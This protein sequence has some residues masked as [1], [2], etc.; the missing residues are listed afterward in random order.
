MIDI[1]RAFVRISA[2]ALV[3]ITAVARATTA[4]SVALIN[5]EFESPYAT[6]SGN[7]GQISGYI[8]NGWSDNSTWSNSSVQYSQEFNNPHSGASCQKMAVSSVGSGEA[9]F[10]QA[11]PVVAGS[12]YTASAWMRGNTGTQVVLRIMDANPPYESYLD[13]YVALTSDWQQVTIHGYIVVSTAASFMIALSAPG[14]VWIDDAS[15]S[16]TPGAAPPTPN[17]G[18][19]PTSFFGIHVGNYL[20]S[21]LSNPGFEPPYISA[22]N[23]NPIS[24]N[25]AVN[26]NDNSSWAD[27][28]VTYS[29]DTQN[30]HSG[31]AAQMVNVQAVRS[32]AVQLVQSVSVIPGATYVFSVWLRGQAGGS[33]NVVLQDQNSPYTYYASTTAQLTANWQQFTASGQINDTGAVLLMVQATSPV[34]FS[35]DDATFTDANGLPVSGGVP[36]PSARFGTLRLW[37]SGTSWTALEPLRG[38]WNFAPLDTSVAAAEANGIEDII[39]TLGQTPSWASSNPDDV[40][41][42]GAGAP[43]P[44][45]NIQDWRD[46]ITA[47]AQRYQGRI[48]HP[49]AVSDGLCLQSHGHFRRAATGRG[50]QAWTGGDP[51]RVAR[52]RRDRGDADVGDDVPVRVMARGGQSVPAVWGAAR[53]GAGHQP[54]VAAGPAE[55]L[56]G[57]RAL[58]T[59]QQTDRVGPDLPGGDGGADLVPRGFRGRRVGDRRRVDRAAWSSPRPARRSNWPCSPAGSRCCWGSR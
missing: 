52:F 3:L 33:V 47:V 17:V 50:G 23:S 9:Q 43:A 45:S 37:D 38:V 39:L 56:A 14:T 34:V 6:V 28:T 29:A 48:R 32:G 53:I 25:V 18:P 35:V 8:A 54:C 31:A 51:H 59:P 4:T 11:M 24:G 30:P 55:G 44:P 58:S 22:G 27:V 15:A 49:D 16:Y 57:H 13:T 1:G 20:Q 36:W 41:Y 12:L 2:T 10:E 42:V 46:Y 40:N 26:W 7:N 5:P 19:I 21:V